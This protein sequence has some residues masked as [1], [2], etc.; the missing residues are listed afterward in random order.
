MVD[1]ASV[2]RWS[3]TVIK[4]RHTECAYY[5]GVNAGKLP[6]LRREPPPGGITAD[7]PRDAVEVTGCLRTRDAAQYDALEM[8]AA[9]RSAEDVGS[10]GN[11]V[12]NRW[13]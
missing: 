1:T 9:R 6:A 10:G 2:A 3:P 11:L 12:R 13:R 5:F 7:L 4:K 8:K